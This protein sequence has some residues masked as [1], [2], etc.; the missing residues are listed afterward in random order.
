MSAVAAT[1]YISE[2]KSGALA[3]GDMDLDPATGEYRFTASVPGVEVND[4]RKT[5]GIRP[6]PLSFGGAVRGVL[7]CSGPLEQPVFSGMPLPTQSYQICL[8]CLSS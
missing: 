6:L 2:V 3:V 1:M 5:L 4:L 8:V 7:H